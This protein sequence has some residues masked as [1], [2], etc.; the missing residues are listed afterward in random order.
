MSLSCSRFDFSNNSVQ[1]MLATVAQCELAMEKS[2]H[3]Y[4]MNQH[5]Q[6]HYQELNTKIGTFH[7]LCTTTHV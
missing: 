7:T 3:V 1:R 6:T 5:E 2:T 4:E